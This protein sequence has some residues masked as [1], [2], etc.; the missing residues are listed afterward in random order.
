[1]L[2]F[3]L[4]DTIVQRCAETSKPQLLK[5]KTQEEKNWYKFLITNS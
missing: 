1:M 2:N 3:K 5:Q 4:P